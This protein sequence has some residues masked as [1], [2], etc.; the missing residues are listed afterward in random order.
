M[1]PKLFRTTTSCLALALLGLFSR[2]SAQQTLS[3]EEALRLAR[4]NNGTIKSALYD[5]KS[6]HSSVV[7][8]RSAFYPTLTPSIQYG[9]QRTFTTGGKIFRNDGTTTGFDATWKILDSGQREF[10]L[11]SSRRSEDATRLD[12][13]Q[14]LRQTLFLVHQQYYDT[15]RFE[16]LVRVSESQVD[17]SQKILE[18][19]E[20]GASDEIGIFAKKD[21]LQARS[22]YLNAKVELLQVKNQ[23]S[24]GEANLKATLGIVN[25]DPL[26][27]LVKIEAPTEFPAPPPREQVIAEGLRDRAD[28]QARRKRIDAQ[29]YNWKRAQREA[30]VSL[31]VDVTYGRNF[32]PN[33]DDN[34]NFTVILSYPLFDGGRLREQARQEQYALEADKALLFQAERQAQAEI[35]SVYAELVQNAERVNAAKLALEAAQLNY[36]AATES[37]KEGVNDLIAVLTAQVS[38][39]TAES[40]YIEATYDYYVSDVNLRLVTGRPIPGETE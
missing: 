2:A 26:P 11:L 19:T 9:N 6:A 20:L 22:D 10:S 14:T 5:V 40:N 4:Q 7:I 28:L 39:V 24:T 16:E 32:S 17:R 31:D 12:A 21:I 29:Y 30:G 27:P 37:M 13:L 25:T 35:E 15:I 1:P 3:L 18:Q 23:S 38:L 34:R 36:T 33:H 8:A